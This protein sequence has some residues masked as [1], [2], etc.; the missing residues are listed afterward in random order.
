MQHELT[1]INHQVKQNTLEAPR[2]QTFEASNSMASPPLENGLLHSTKSNFVEGIDC[3][4]CPLPENGAIDI[5]DNVSIEASQGWPQIDVPEETCFMPIV[6][7]DKEGGH[8]FET[9]SLEGSFCLVSPKIENDL[10]HTIEKS[11]KLRK[12][13]SL[14]DR[15]DNES[16]RTLEQQSSGCHVLFAPINE[17]AL[18]LYHLVETTEAHDVCVCNNIDITA[19][20]EALSAASSKRAS[21]LNTLERNSIMLSSKNADHVQH[22]LSEI[23][24]QVKQNTLKARFKPLKHQILWPAHCLKMVYCTQLNLIFWKGFDCVSYPLPEN[25][26]IDIVDNI[27]IETSQGWPQIDVP[28]ETYSMPIVLLDK[29]GGHSFKTTFLKG[30]FCFGQSKDGK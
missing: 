30:P 24:H 21:V 27:S 28:E 3:V 22:E 19:R 29:E 25:G 20:P 4:S 23:N 7:L 5:V 11:R 6:P 26:A 10:L 14:L 12:R 9:T 16:F 17:S 8:S 18:Q 2:F 1:E 15:C 13:S